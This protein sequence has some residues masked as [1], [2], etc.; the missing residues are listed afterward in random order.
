MLRLQVLTP[1][2]SS[3]NGRAFLFPLL[4]WRRALARRGIETRLVRDLVGI[5]DSDVLVVDSKFHRDRWLSDLDGILA[6]FAVLRQRTAKLIYCDTTDSSGWL[7]TELLPLVDRYWKFQLLRDRDAYLQPMYG[8]RIFTHF[9]HRTYG[10]TDRK[11]LDKLDVAWNSGLADYSF[12]GLYRMAA[13][14]RLPISGFLK[15]PA[16]AFRSPDHPRKNEIS[17][18]FGSGYSRASVAWQRQT[19]KARLRDRLPT[20]RLSRRQY[21]AELWNSRLVLSPFGFGEICYRDFEAFVAGGLLI[22]PDMSH[23]ETWP[24]LFRNGETYVAHS[25]NLEDLD[26]II[27]DTAAGYGQLIEIAKAGQESYWQ[28]TVGPHAGEVFCD[29]VEQLIAGADRS[30]QQHG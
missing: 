13:Y 1:G 8:H 21:F 20:E 2:F 29:H 27:E 11:L 16:S 5:T 30:Q 7:Q 24:N 19:I 15:F 12:F 23:L 17:C 9:Y 6:D 28:H 26:A 4:V 25:W 3:P 14:M 18:R 10:V 22:K